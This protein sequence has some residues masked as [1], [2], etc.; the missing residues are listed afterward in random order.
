[1][2]PTLGYVYLGVACVFLVSIE[3]TQNGL[4]R[5]KGVYTPGPAKLLLAVLWPAT[6][7]AIVILTVLKARGKR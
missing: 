6:L 3:L 1:M 4:H 5:A 2:L 7:G